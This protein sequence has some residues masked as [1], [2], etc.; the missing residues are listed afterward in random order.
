MGFNII[1]IAPARSVFGSHREMLILLIMLNPGEKNI[2][3]GEMLLMLIMLI[4]LNHIGDSLGNA[5]LDL[6][7]LLTF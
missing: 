2:L 6:T 4:M 3:A 5:E 1:N 7:T